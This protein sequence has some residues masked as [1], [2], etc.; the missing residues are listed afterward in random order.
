MT[1]EKLLKGFKW[2]FQSFIWLAVIAL[3]IDIVSKN[4]VYAGAHAMEGA[5]VVDMIP[6][7]LRIRLVF[8]NAATFGMGFSDPLIN[9][10]FFICCAGLASIAIIVFFV[11]KFKKLG[12]YMKA[13][14]MLI[15]SGA[16]GNLTDRIFYGFSNYCVVDWIDFYGIWPHIFNIA[17]SCVVVGVILLVIF[18][19]VDEVKEYKA[20]KAR[21]PEPKG[22]VL[23]KEEQ[24]RID[25]Q[26]DDKTSK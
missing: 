16:L 25:A 2:F 26:N 4:L 6:G 17:D 8:N 20:T 15:L 1:K 7:F 19:I 22:K 11:L 24:A 21:N 18:L 9:R 23:S 10:I 14:L 3:V 5:T 12:L 13:C